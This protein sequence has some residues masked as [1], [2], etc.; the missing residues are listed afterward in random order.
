MIVVKSFIPENAHKKDVN[1][2]GLS[3]K[4]DNDIN[5]IAV[6]ASGRVDG[7]KLRPQMI[8]ENGWWISQEDDSVILGQMEFDGDWKESLL[9]V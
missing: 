6:D 7:Y 3:I 8:P 4:V 5:F 2:H 1:F 9:E